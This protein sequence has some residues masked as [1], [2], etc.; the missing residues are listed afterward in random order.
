MSLAFLRTSEVR[1]FLDIRASEGHR[2]FC[3]ARQDKKWAKEARDRD[4]EWYPRYLK[5][6]IPQIRHQDQGLIVLLISCYLIGWSVLQNS[7]QLHAG[8]WLRIDRRYLKRSGA[9]RSCGFGIACG[10]DSVAV[11]TS[12][13]FDCG[14]QQVWL[15]QSSEIWGVTSEKH[16][17]VWKNINSGEYEQA[18]TRP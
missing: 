13:L 4:R 3:R 11:R 2:E 16:C 10:C 8:E 7:W 9:S 1:S 18:R 14:L 12:K 6:D 15:G 17:Q 5:I